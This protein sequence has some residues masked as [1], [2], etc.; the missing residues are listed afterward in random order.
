MAKWKLNQGGLQGG[1]EY[2]S[3]SATGESSWQLYQDEKPFLEQAK[4]DR[5][6]GTK[7]NIM[8]AKKFA[9]IPEI[10]AIEIKDKWG[11]DIHA[12]DFLHDDHKKAKFFSI[13]Q[14][15]LLPPCRKQQ[16]RGKLWLLHSM[17][18]S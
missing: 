18:L 2:D 5:E 14:N 12:P 6:Q 16:I 11:I 1:F 10:V 8:G 9:T 7:D 15:R 17:M 13:I 3:G 4:R